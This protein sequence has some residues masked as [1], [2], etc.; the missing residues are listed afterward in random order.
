[1]TDVSALRPGGGDVEAVKGPLSIRSRF[2][3]RKTAAAAS[4]LLK[5][6]GGQMR[7]LRLIKLLYMADR[8]SWQRFNRPITG[9]RYVSMDRGPVLS[10]TYNLIRE[11]PPGAWSEAIERVDRYEV[12]LKGEP[13]LGPLSEAEI[14]LL[15]DAFGLFEQMDHWHLVKH[16]HRT[17]SEWKDPKGSAATIS[18]EEILRALGKSEEEVEEARQVSAETSYF[19]ALFASR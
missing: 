13:D 2:D 7:Y 12:R 15:K 1:L 19:D 10:R 8:A 17:L 9:D 5:E 18:P 3:E 4:V 16:L 6:A 11:E 14:E